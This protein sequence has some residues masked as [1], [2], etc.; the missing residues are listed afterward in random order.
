[1]KFSVSLL[2]L[3]SHLCF[4]C[5]FFSVK[6]KVIQNSFHEDPSLMRDQINFSHDLI[7]NNVTDTGILEDYIFHKFP[8][9]HVTENLS[10]DVLHEILEGISL[11]DFGLI[12]NHFI[13]I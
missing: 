10:V 4:F 6:K 8:D 2:V 13:K 12:L 7:K 9:Y 11:Y 1:M 5:R 3:I